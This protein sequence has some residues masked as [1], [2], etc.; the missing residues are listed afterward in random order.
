MHSPHPTGFAQMRNR[1][2]C[3]FR[4]SEVPDDDLSRDG[5]R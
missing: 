5:F 1:P 4:E 3:F 2:L